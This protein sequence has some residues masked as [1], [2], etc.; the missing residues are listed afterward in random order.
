[1]VRVA[2]TTFDS[3]VLLSHSV[4]PGGTVSSGGAAGAGRAGAGPVEPRTTRRGGG[5][6]DGGGGTLV[7]EL[8]QPPRGGPPQPMTSLHTV[9]E[10][11]LDVGGQL[12]VLVAGDRELVRHGDAARRPRPRARRWPS[13]RWRRRSRWAGRPGRA[14]SG[15]PRL[16]P[17][18]RSRPRRTVPGASP[19]PARAAAQASRRD[20]P[21]TSS[22]GPATWAIRVCPSPTRCST[23]AAMPGASSTPT[24]GQRD[25][26]QVRS[27][28]H[29]GQSELGEQ[30]GAG[31]VDVQVGEEDAVDA[32]LDAEPA[33]A[34]VLG[35]VL[36]DHLE[37]Q[38]VAVLATARSRRRR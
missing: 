26:R 36:G 28:D 1:M 21:W 3:H 19:A 7:D 16:R 27:D 30:G 10:G 6:L 13:G 38:R 4:L 2:V 5:E 12:G 8:E 37:E 29:R 23:A 33:V 22:G 17:R 9:V 20:R 31:V 14:A 15:W 24:E 34:L 32:A 11:R 18:R 35:V 25:L